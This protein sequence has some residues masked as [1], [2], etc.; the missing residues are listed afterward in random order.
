MKWM[1]K[2]KHWQVFLILLTATFINSFKVEENQVFTS[3]LSLIGGLIYFS[4]WLAVGRGLFQRLP[5]GI[6]LNYNFFIVNAFV[7]L[8]AY[9]TVML[10]SDGQGMTFSG[11][12]AIPGFYV[13]FAFLHF[14][15]FPVR[16]LKSIENKKKASIRECIGDFLLLVF[17]PIGTWFLQPRINK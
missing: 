15:M 4:W 6:N 16:V 12:E 7:W 11:L 17:F 1:R 9:A 5:T 10:L 13:F 14:L 8:I 2:L 3:I